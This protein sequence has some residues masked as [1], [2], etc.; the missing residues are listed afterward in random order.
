MWNEH[1]DLI[2]KWEKILGEAVNKYW[3][4][5]MYPML[6]IPSELLNSY[7]VETKDELALIPFVQSRLYLVVNDV[8]N[9]Y[10]K[11]DEEKFHAIQRI[12]DAY[13]TISCATK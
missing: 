8:N 12:L 13:F 1:R 2:K 3:S 10:N 6:Q 4:E 9:V 5:V 11:T 7:S